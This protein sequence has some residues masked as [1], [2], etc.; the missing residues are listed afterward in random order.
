M[1]PKEIYSTEQVRELDRIA[2]E[3]HGISGYELMQRAGAATFK[4][5]IRSWPEAKSLQV[6]CGQGN[7]GGDGYVIARLAKEAGMAVELIALGDV[8]TVTGD[9]L[10]AR[11]DWL[12]QSGDD[13]EVS[14]AIDINVKVDVIVDAIFGTGL[15]RPPEGEWLRSINVINASPAKTIAVDVPSGLDS[16]TGMPLTAAVVADKTVTFIGVKQGLLTAKAG[17]Y[18]GEL[19][20]DALDLPQSVYLHT[21]PVA[22]RLTLSLISSLLPK[23]KLST[24]KG[25]CGHALIIGGAMGMQGAA[26]MT[27]EACARSGAGL[28]TLGTEQGYPVRPEIMSFTTND[29]LRL[30]SAI[31]RATVIAIGP[32]LGIEEEANELLKKI[33][34]SS[35]PLVI[36]A[37]AL[38]LLA[39][40]PEDKCHRN[41]WILTPHPGEAARLL[42]TST[43]NIQSNRIESVKAIQNRYGGVCILKG[44]GSLIYDGDRLAI[45]T[46]GNPG[47]ATGGMGDV[48]TG[49][50][51]GLLAQKLS[52]YD[53]ARTAVY[54]HAKAA[55]SAVVKEGEIGLLAADLF[56]YIRQWVNKATIH[57]TGLNITGT[58]IG[59]NTKP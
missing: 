6:Y 31:E 29:V 24:H 58:H 57:I 25:D 4:S 53:A 20:F 59:E 13:T 7:N 28:I 49:V 48:L 8:N 21:I 3:E 10:K 35:K 47:M 46:N 40:F 50:T 32:G 5:L 33:M 45:C 15:S 51:C 39:S 16:D 23:R 19:E 27:A 41:N 12:L 22:E 36:D 14:H 42:N 37:D 38:N 9:A 54:I 55:D 30:E 2:I 56:P 18:T 1:L 17:D 11:Q 34:S 52:L 44:F 43:A 26:Q